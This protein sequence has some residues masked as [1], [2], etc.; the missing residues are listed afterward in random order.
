MHSTDDSFAPQGPSSY[1]ATTAANTRA[2]NV[3]T[4]IHVEF[5]P[6]EAL[7]FQDGTMPP[8]S[9]FVRGQKK[10]GVA[11]KYVETQIRFG[12]GSMPSGAM[13]TEM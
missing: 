12:S 9:R 5:E 4:I 10:I 6:S 13:E 2:K 3:M 11:W 1:E 7:M 8:P